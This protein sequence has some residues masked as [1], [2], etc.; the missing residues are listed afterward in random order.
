MRG[1]DDGEHEQ[2]AAKGAEEAAEIDLRRREALA[3][4]DERRAPRHVARVVGRHRHEHQGEEGERR[5]EESGPAGEF[6]W[7][8]GEGE[9]GEEDA[10]EDGEADEGCW[11]GRGG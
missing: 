3:Q 5:A 7:H 8:G 2:Q 10:A 9:F 11:G 1:D 4:A 6:G